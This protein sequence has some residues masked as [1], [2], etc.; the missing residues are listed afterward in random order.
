VTDEFILGELVGGFVEDFDEEAV[1]RTL[2][3][4]VKLEVAWRHWEKYAT[5]DLVRNRGI[6]TKKKDERFE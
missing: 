6:H 3:G 2:G 5:I 4:L 1:G